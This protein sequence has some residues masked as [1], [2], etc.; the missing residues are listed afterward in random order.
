MDFQTGVVLMRCE[1]QGQ[2]YP[3]TNVTKNKSGFPSEFAALSTSIWHDRLGHPGA[4][5]LDSLIPN[6]KIN[7]TFCHSCPLGKHVKNAIY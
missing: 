3:I 7:S 4:S 5:I 1:S 6:S 2:L